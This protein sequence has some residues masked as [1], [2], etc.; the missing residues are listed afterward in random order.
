[1]E[2]ASL[3]QRGL[4]ETAAAC[5]VNVHCRSAAAGCRSGHDVDARPWTLGARQP[6]EVSQADLRRL[7]GGLKRGPE[8]VRDCRGLRT[9]WFCLRPVSRRRALGISS[10]DGWKPIAEGDNL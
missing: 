3:P 9:A 8:T 4:H 5:R 10:F 6:R 1:M 2:A 7:G